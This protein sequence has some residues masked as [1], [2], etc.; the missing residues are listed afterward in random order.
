VTIYFVRHAKAG[1]RSRWDG[2]DRVRPLSPAG[3]KQA[4]LI[5]ARLGEVRTT[6]LV[7]SP[8][9]RCMQT[10]EPLAALTGATVV[11]DERLAEDE[12]F[13]PVVALLEE[14]PDF[15]VLCSHGDVIPETIAALQRRGL[16]VTDIPDWRKATVWL[17]ERNGSGVFTSGSVWP[18]PDR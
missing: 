7:S 11:A 8:F 14:L 6:M 1:H 9:A 17:L 10:L 13:G 16:L 4:K 2:D 3:R 5:A 18:P 15:S 12:P